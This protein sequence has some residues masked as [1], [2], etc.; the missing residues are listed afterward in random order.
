VNKKKRSKHQPLEIKGVEGRCYSPQV[1]E[2]P[3]PLPRG[4]GGASIAPVGASAAPAGSS[5]DDL[6]AGASAPATGPSST[7]ASAACGDGGGG[8]HLSGAAR[9]PLLSSSS[10]G[11]DEFASASGG[12][13]PCCSRSRYSSS[14]YSWRSRHLSLLSFALAAHS[15]SRRYSAR[16]IDR[17]RAL[18][19]PTA[20]RARSPTSGKSCQG[21]HR[22]DTITREE[23]RGAFTVGA[24]GSITN[25]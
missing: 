1:G 23:R 22:R 17:A 15:C 5:T 16:A 10:D 18:A 13:S 8:F 14:Y 4:L 7:A 21:L 25:D 2:A 12:E 3:L 11:D 6:T 9:P 24:S 20:R 19:G